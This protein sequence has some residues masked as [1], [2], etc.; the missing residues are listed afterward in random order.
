MSV[1]CCCTLT[2]STRNTL[3]LPPS[4]SGVVK[5][6]GES[7]GTLVSRSGSLL[8][9]RKVIDVEVRASVRAVGEYNQ[10]VACVVGL[11]CLQGFAKSFTVKWVHNIVEAAQLDSNLR[12]TISF[13]IP[14]FDLSS[15]SFTATLF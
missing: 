3:L 12:A 1:L 9:V 14:S 15:N 7:S 8:S 13:I 5:S 6:S 11:E 10:D 4:S 2:R